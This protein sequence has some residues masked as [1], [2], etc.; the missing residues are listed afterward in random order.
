MP[1]SAFARRRRNLRTGFGRDLST[2]PPFFRS[3]RA[4]QKSGS[5]NKS[6]CSLCD[7]LKNVFER[8]FAHPIKCNRYFLDKFFYFF[9][10]IAQSVKVVFCLSCKATRRALKSLGGV[11]G[12]K[13]GRYSNGRS[14]LF[15]FYPIE[16]GGIGARET[17][18]HGHKVVAVEEWGERRGEMHGCLVGLWLVDRGRVAEEGGDRC[19]ES[20][21]RTPASQNLQTPANLASYSSLLPVCAWHA[22]SCHLHALKSES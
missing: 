22:R 10:F 14:L 12:P 8:L 11:F 3:I 9:S 4:R 19:A 17:P 15:L 2:K 13:A 1:L 5:L 18:S 16:D 6:A 7:E 20:I 21:N